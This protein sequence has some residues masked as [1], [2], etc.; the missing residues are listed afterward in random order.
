MASMEN[1]KT[2]ET[3]HMAM[4]AF[5]MARGEDKGIKLQGVKDIRS[6]NM[7]GTYVFTGDKELIKSLLLDFQ[8]SPE[9]KFDDKIRYLKS[10]CKDKARNNI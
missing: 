7:T 3:S 5:V 10:L 4:A 1:D 9:K 8:N 6:Y 2:W